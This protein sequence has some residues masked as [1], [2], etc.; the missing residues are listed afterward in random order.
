M[1]LEDFVQLATCGQHC[2]GCTIVIDDSRVIFKSVGTAL[3][4]Y[5]MKH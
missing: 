1:R 4:S 5:F 3:E 2:K